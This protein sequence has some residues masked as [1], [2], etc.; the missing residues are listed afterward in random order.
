MGYIGKELMNDFR[1]AQRSEVPYVGFLFDAA[2]SSKLQIAHNIRLPVLF[3]I[4]LQCRT[5]CF[6]SFDNIPLLYANIGLHSPKQKDKHQV[7]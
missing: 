5:S 3:A 1:T 6:Y 4:E 2:F 7:T